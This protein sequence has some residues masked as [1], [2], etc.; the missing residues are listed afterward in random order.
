[1]RNTLVPLLY[2]TLVYSLQLSAIQCMLRLL[3][4]CLVS[5]GV[6]CRGMDARAGGAQLRAHAWLPP[7]EGEHGA[8]A[9]AEP[10][11]WQ[12]VVTYC[13]GG[14]YD[15]TSQ[16]RVVEVYRLLRV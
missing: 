13:T 8:T 15:T 9:G 5:N 3:A 4:P 10:E 11:R 2:D 6:V 16:A 7:R 14:I 12:S 1:M